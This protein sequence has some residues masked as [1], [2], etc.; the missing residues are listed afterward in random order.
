MWYFLGK[1]KQAM[2]E[3]WVNVEKNPLVIDA[4]I[5]DKLKWLDKGIDDDDNDEDNGDDK[6]SNGSDNDKKMDTDTDTERDVVMIAAAVQKKPNLS[7][8]G[9]EDKLK[10]VREYVSES[11]APTDNIDVLLC[12]ANN[13]RANNTSKA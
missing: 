8:N 10:E 1:N 3:E 9:A 6:N 5:D 13:L 12:V 2:E 7:L 11:G 4:E